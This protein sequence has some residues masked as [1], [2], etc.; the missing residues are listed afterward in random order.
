MSHEFICL[1][2]YHT[3]EKLTNPSSFSAHQ[4]PMA[5]SH[6]NYWRIASCKDKYYSK[7]DKSI[8]GKKDNKYTR[9]N[10]PSQKESY[11]V[12]HKVSQLTNFPSSEGIVPDS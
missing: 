9:T 5:S 11:K 1:V 3:T 10:Y 8:F 2:K 12:T 6:S 4:V 7:I